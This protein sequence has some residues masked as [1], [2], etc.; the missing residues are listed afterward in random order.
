[1]WPFFN[2]LIFFLH[3]HI[4]CYLCIFYSFSS[5][6]IQKL[7]V[8]VR[9]GIVSVLCFLHCLA[10]CFIQALLKLLSAP[11]IETVCRGRCCL[12]NSDPSPYS[13]PI[14]EIRNHLSWKILFSKVITSPNESRMFCFSEALGKEGQYFSVSLSAWLN[15]S[16]DSTMYARNCYVRN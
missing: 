2:Q 8:Y 3:F 5:T 1:M 12:K 6:R 4:F 10:L 15:Q 11:K 16:V 14:G 13:N 7:K 9:A